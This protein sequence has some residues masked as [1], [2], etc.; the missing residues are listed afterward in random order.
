[1]EIFGLVYIA[2]NPVNNKCYIGTTTQALSKRRK[3]HK[4]HMKSNSH[5][6]LVKAFI[7]HGFDN[8]T[9]KTIDTAVSR[10]QLNELEIMYIKKHD[11]TNRQNGYNVQLGGINAAHH[12]DTIKNMRRGYGN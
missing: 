1:M 4:W 9:W 7:K 5:L 3:E 10:K 2:K 11:S 8:F 12:P 6:P